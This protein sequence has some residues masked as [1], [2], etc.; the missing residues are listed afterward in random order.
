MNG[1]VLCLDAGNRKSYPGSGT[2]WTDLSGNNGNGSLING[3]TYS[4]S[5]GGSIV[6]DGTND[7]IHISSPSRK[8][9]WSP[10]GSTGNRVISFECWVKTTDSDNGLIFSKPWNGGGVYNYL[11]STSNFGTRVGNA[12]HNLSFT[13][14]SDGNWKQIV[15][16]A[17][18][19]QKAVYINGSLNAGYTNHNETSDVPSGSESTLNLTLMSLFPYGDTIS[20]PEQAIVGDMSIFRMY[21]RELTAAEIRQNFNALR[22]RFGI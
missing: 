17:N 19:T 2:T 22:G 21:N 7:R 5:N 20:R 12:Q 18:E 1:L 15:A 13:A 11:L 9:A 3:P 8:Y 14:V 6:F 16:I 4:S 10:V